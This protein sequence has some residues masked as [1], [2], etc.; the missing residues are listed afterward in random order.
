MRPDGCGFPHPA[1]DAAP[2]VGCGACDA[3]CPALARRPK[4]EVAG[5][6][7]AKSK[8][9]AE[10]LASS[11]GGVFA[12]LAREVLN[13]GGVVCGAAWA[14]GCRH[15]RHV[16]VDS[17]EGLDS[18]MRSKYVQSS[19]GREVYEGVR[20]ALRAGRRVLFSGTACQVAGMRAYLGR[21]ADSD[22]FLAVDVICHGV[23]SPLLWERWAEHCEGLAG[24][25]LRAV[26]MRSPTTGWLSYST[27]YES[28][29]EQDGAPAR[30]GSVFGDDWFMKAFLSNAS[31]RPSCFA[32]P[33]KRSCGSDV[34]LGDFWGV[35]SAHPEVDYE[36]GVSAVLAN[37]AKGVAA[38][39]A[40]KSRLEWGVSSV[41][42]VIPGNSCLFGSAV[43]YNK[44]ASFLTDF[45][46]GTE[47]DSLLAKYDFKQTLM[48]RL[49]GY[50]SR[51]K[52]K[53]GKI[54]RVR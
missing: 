42:K 27:A 36:G 7:W 22:G 4:D 12:L 24:A 45:A 29:A 3:V 43:P 9:G 50:A 21:L 41:E 39:E 46:A 34:T 14:D 38:V 20:G 2:C 17:A 33:A 19:V 15:V 25:P 1:V 54:L 40:L 30:D 11:S 47:F 28:A 5:V 49:G 51:L 37:T 16:L 32:C 8:D 31:L 48:E 52:R 35:Q 44:E 23:P 13:V 26:N 53:V 6:V 10:R 18:V